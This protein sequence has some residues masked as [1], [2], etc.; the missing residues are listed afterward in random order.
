MYNY[1]FKNKT[2]WSSKGT[3]PMSATQN[4]YFTTPS[5]IDQIQATGAYLLSSQPLLNMDSHLGNIAQVF[6][7]NSKRFHVEIAFDGTVKVVPTLTNSYTGTCFFK[8]DGEIVV[9]AA[10]VQSGM[11]CFFLACIVLNPIDSARSLAFNYNSNLQQASTYPSKIALEYCKL[12]LM[13]FETEGK[14]PIFLV[15]QAKALQQA[16]NDAYNILDSSVKQYCDFR[17]YTTMDFLARLVSNRTIFNSDSGSVFGKLEY[18]YWWQ[19]L[20]QV[21]GMQSGIFS[22][23]NLNIKDVSQFPVGASS[24]LN[25]GKDYISDGKSFAVGSIHWYN[26]GY[27]QF[28]R[29]EINLPSGETYRF[30]ANDLLNTIFK[31]NQSSSNLD[32]IAFT[33]GAEADQYYFQ[34]R[35]EGDPTAEVT[36]TGSTQ[37]RGDQYTH[38]Y[39]GNTL[40]PIEFEGPVTMSI[41]GTG[42]NLVVPRTK[43]G[44]I[45]A[46]STGGTNLT[47]TAGAGVSVN[48][49]LPPATA[50]CFFDPFSDSWLEAMETQARA[51]INSTADYVKYTKKYSD[52]GTINLGSSVADNQGYVA[53]Y[54]QDVNFR[55]NDAA[56]KRLEQSIYYPTT[57]NDINWINTSIPAYAKKIVDGSDMNVYTSVVIPE[58]Q[59][60]QSDLTTAANGYLGSEALTTMCQHSNTLYID[61]SPLQK[62]DLMRS[63]VLAAMNGRFLMENIGTLT[64]SSNYIMPA[65]SGYLNA[66]YATYGT[67]VNDSY[68]AVMRQVMTY[69]IART[70]NINNFYKV[71]SRLGGLMS[72]T[73]GSSA[74]W[75][76]NQNISAWQN[77]TP[78]TLASATSI[79]TDYGAPNFYPFWN[80][81]MSAIKTG[82]AAGINWTKP[83]FTQS[84]ASAVY[85]YVANASA[86]Y[87]AIQ[88]TVNTIL[89]NIVTLMD[90]WDPTNAYAINATGTFMVL[91]TMYRALQRYN[92]IKGNYRTR[93]QAANNMFA[94]RPALYTACTPGYGGDSSYTDMVNGWAS[95]PFNPYQHVL[96]N[97]INS[98]PGSAAGVWTKA[99][100]LTTNDQW[101]IFINRMTYPNG[102]KAVG[103]V[104]VANPTQTLDP[105]T[106]GELIMDA[107]VDA[108]VDIN[109]LNSSWI[110]SFVNA[111]SS[112]NEVVSTAS[113]L[114][115][116]ASRTWG[117]VNTLTYPYDM[118]STGINLRL[119]PIPYGQ[120][121]MFG[122]SLFQY[123]DNSNFT[124]ITA[125]KP[126]ATGTNTSDRSYPNGQTGAN[127]LFAPTY[128]GNGPN[129]LYKNGY[130]K[131]AG[132][133]AYQRFTTATS[134]SAPMDFHFQNPWGVES[135]TSTNYRY[136]LYLMQ[137]NLY[138]TNQNS[139]VVYA[140]NTTNY[141]RTAL[142]TALGVKQ[143]AITDG[144]V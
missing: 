135:I 103:Q 51:N 62:P 134:S 42:A 44:P 113:T 92:I 41:G 60:G 81:M 58:K 29:C 8:A 48:Y 140:F 47:V 55:L 49:Y 106:W 89:P 112:I 65:T 128:Q 130:I 98:S 105:Q 88:S 66:T 126:N 87:T 94:S 75:N 97:F 52:I 111:D 73:K 117:S 67:G 121:R 95:N 12:K 136:T 139:P 107:I 34:V 110:L 15:S 36:S 25:I 116:K 76:V 127:A 82:A 74:G 40:Y 102:F 138:T 72:W 133:S 86:A 21:N 108:L 142:N 83:Y 46:M 119:Y 50:L 118:D 69:P 59:F 16:C 26:M 39:I 144:I 27:F 57:N 120:E 4:V 20:A 28:K 6:Q 32:L 33:V 77:P 13:E 99:N 64:P 22:N 124:Y 53:A 125:L 18:T 61:N 7:M 54:A 31:A 68:F 3:P 14:L 122:T 79:Y 17:S 104:D 11:Y 1:F 85:P 91:A 84:A 63:V 35:L 90:N 141:N 10:D 109:K 114:L 56:C 5:V 70:R 37:S 101:Q 96:P 137:N 24:F 23:N 131:Q 115:D 9:N 2:L 43:Y 100:E 132:G 78:M 30:I 45:F 38:Y 143:G 71:Y 129:T 80:D 93:L 19:Y 123:Y